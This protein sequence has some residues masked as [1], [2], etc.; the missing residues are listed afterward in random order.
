MWPFEWMIV[1]GWIVL[2][3]WFSIGAMR[4]MATMGRETQARLIMGEYVEVLRNAGDAGL[5][6]SSR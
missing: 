4:R 5:K 3:A 6:G 1:I 2:G